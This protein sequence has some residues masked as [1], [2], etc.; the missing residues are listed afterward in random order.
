M[1]IAASIMPYIKAFGPALIAII[2][3]FLA[4]RWRKKLDNRLVNIIALLQAH[5]QS[6][7]RGTGSKT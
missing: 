4:W 3:V 2:N 7:F 1:E 6:R 5:S